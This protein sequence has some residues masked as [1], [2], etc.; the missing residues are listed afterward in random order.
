MIL[1]K[2]VHGNSGVKSYY[3]GDDYILIEFNDAYYLYSF[4]SAGYEAVVEMKR[5]AKKGKG[6]SGFISKHIRERYEKMYKDLKEME[7]YL[8]RRL[9]KS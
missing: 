5:K 4:D 8:K 7:S 2:N 6:L 1:Y 9:V 3:L